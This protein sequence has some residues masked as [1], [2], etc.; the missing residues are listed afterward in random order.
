[1][2]EPKRIFIIGSFNDELP[3]SIRIERRHWTKGFVRLGHDVQRFSYRNIMIQLSPIR[4][5]TIARHFAKKHADRAL[6]TQIKCYQPD[7][8]LI[9][10]MKDIDTETVVAMRQAAPKAIFVGRDVNWFP[11]R[12][13]ARISMARKLDII[14]ASNAGDFLKTYKEAGV[15][16]C[17][18]IPCPCDPDIHRPY[19]VDELYKTDIIF[20]GKAVHSKHKTDGDR[21]CIVRRLSKM[22]NARV[23]GCFG[24]P[25]IEGI[26]CFYAISGAKIALSINAINN[27]RLYHSDRLTAYLACGTFV[28]AKRVPDT[29]LLFEDG[30]HLKYFDTVDEFFELAEWYLNHENE[31]EKIAKAGMQ[32][33]H[34]EFNCVKMA[35][36]VIDLIEKGRY[37][38]PWA[39]I[40]S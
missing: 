26:D 24:N 32:R 37:D 27:I 20:T 7:V 35:Q 39:E 19:E 9:V 3:Q 28:L 36:Y 15:P 34:T 8:V 6:I 11:E 21:Y 29:D 10:T 22:P 12:D 13:T 25:Q 1:M 4:S 18:F 33:A 31:R 14:V 40:L 17:A 16:C 23:Y 2:S 38:K 5:K 30:V